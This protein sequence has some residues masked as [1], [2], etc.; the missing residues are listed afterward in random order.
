M[1]IID[2]AATI[3]T[4]D[5]ATLRAYGFTGD[6]L[7]HMTALVPHLDTMNE[8]HGVHVRVLEMNLDE[9]QTAGQPD[10]SRLGELWGMLDQLKELAIG[11]D[12]ETALTKH[13][14]YKITAEVSAD[15]PAST[16]EY[17]ADFTAFMAV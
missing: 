2:H 6:Q 8:R 17:L 7:T 14:T 16:L 5:H 13:N 10:F 15:T 1:T 11:A 4:S 3:T 12:I 9:L